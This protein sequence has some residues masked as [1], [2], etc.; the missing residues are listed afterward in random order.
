MLQESY[1][2]KHMQK[3][4]D[5]TDRRP[6]INCGPANG[7]SLTESYWPKLQDMSLYGYGVP[8]HSR[9]PELGDTRDVAGYNWDTRNTSA[10]SPLQPSVTQ[11]TAEVGKTTSS[12][13][14][15]Q[16]QKHNGQV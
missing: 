10:F 13:F 8:D 5:R 9:L 15:P 12:P 6:P 4:S 14:D 16:F 1:L 3:H 11:S 2:A 7:L